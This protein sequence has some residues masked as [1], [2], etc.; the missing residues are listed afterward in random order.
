MPACRSFWLIALMPAWGALQAG[1]PP[2]HSPVSTVLTSTSRPVLS[3]D[4]KKQLGLVPEYENLRAVEHLKIA[5]LD[6]GFDG[7]DGVRP[8]LPANTVLVEHYDPE[9]IRRH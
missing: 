1:D 6:Y 7:I 4:M 3:A 8:Y 5:V 9:F 2:P